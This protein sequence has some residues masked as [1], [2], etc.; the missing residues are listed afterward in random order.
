MT[1]R[2]PHNPGRVDWSGENPGI[3]LKQDPAQE[4]YDTLALFFRVVL[5]PYGR[6]HAA[7]ILGAPDQACGWPHAP[8]LIMTDNQRMMRWIVD[9]WV[10]KM[11]TFINKAGLEAM[12]WLDCDSVE[13]RPSDL[14]TRYSETLRGS[15]VTVDMI[16]RDMGPPLPVEVTKENSATKAHE[17]YSV[18]LEA[19]TAQVVINGTPL[20]G[21][22]ADRQFFGRKMSTAFL[23]F[24]ETWVTPQEDL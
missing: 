15:G 8:N 3:Y 6:G 10:T 19:K 23:A 1:T 2:T 20:P 9:G 16:W 21:D 12:T 7:L 24:S 13:K 18:F 11:P 14:K 4:R 17:M 5:S 22:V